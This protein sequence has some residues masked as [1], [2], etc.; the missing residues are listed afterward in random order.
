[1]GEQKATDPSLVRPR[2]W[3]AERL[4]RAEMERWEVSRCRA[5]EVQ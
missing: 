5:M 4:V 1:M 2:F 3:V